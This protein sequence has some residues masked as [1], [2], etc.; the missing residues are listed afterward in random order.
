MKKGPKKGPRKC[1]QATILN[2]AVQGGRTRAHQVHPDLDA[3]NSAPKE[4]PNLRYWF[5]EFVA[6]TNTAGDN[7]AGTAAAIFS[8]ARKF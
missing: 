8:D 1:R 6:Q 5:K 2:L 3:H 7:S 4:Q